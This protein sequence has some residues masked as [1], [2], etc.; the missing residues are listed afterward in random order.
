MILHGIERML[1]EHWCHPHTLNS[2]CPIPTIRH[3]LIANPIRFRSSSIIL[4]NMES[5]FDADADIM[6]MICRDC[7]SANPA[8]PYPFVLG[9][10]PLP[11]TEFHSSHSSEAEPFR[12]PSHLG[13]QKFLQVTWGRTMKLEEDTLTSLSRSSSCNKFLAA[14]A[15]SSSSWGRLSEGWRRS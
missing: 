5:W 11:S 12:N 4:N 3:D 13:R 8:Y 2:I 1:P 6:E 10:I 7:L 14:R 15:M 9:R